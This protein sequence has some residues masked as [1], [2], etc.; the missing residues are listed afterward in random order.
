MVLLSRVR[1]PRYPK[2][3]APP[4]VLLAGGTVIDRY[5]Q[6]LV[7]LAAGTVIDRYHQYLVPL[8]GGTVIDWYH[9]YLV[10]LMGGATGGD[11]GDRSPAI[12]S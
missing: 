7:P 3:V 1:V 2:S 5:H 9:Q 4:L 12:E 11:G 10:L 8:A 6:Y